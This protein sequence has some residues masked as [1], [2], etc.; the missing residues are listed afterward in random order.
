M[1]VFVRPDPPG[2]PDIALFDR[3]VSA[4]EKQM[5]HTPQYLDGLEVDH[6]LK[7]WGARTIS[8]ATAA[9]LSCCLTTGHDHA[10]FNRSVRRETRSIRSRAPPPPGVN[11][12]HTTVYAPDA[13]RQAHDIA[14]TVGASAERPL[15]HWSTGSKFP[16]DAGITAIAKQYFE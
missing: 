10:D 11:F 16:H 15:L 12:E 1:I 14:S 3:V 13:C 6:E 4:A 5:R 8:P 2:P 9:S 7:P